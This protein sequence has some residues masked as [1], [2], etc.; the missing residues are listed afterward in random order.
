MSGAKRTSNVGAQSERVNVAIRGSFRN[1][2]GKAEA[3][4][5][6]DGPDGEDLLVLTLFSRQP[7]YGPT[8][9]ADDVRQLPAPARTLVGAW[10]G[11]ARFDGA[12]PSNR[13]D[14]NAPLLTLTV[15]LGD[16]ALEF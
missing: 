12:G 1:E 16:Y 3:V 4:P 8:N 7:A 6:L 2:E 10:R 11:S 13:D 9:R 5:G 14:L 15:T